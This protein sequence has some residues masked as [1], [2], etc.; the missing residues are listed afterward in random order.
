MKKV[1]IASIFATL[2]LTVPMTSVV[3][4]SVTITE[5]HPPEAPMIH[6]P[7]RV[8]PGLELVYTFNAMDP[9]GDNVS[10]FVEWGDGTC[11]GWTY[12]FP[13][14]T[15]VSFAH[16]WEQKPKY[17]RAKAKDYPY[18]AESNWS[19][20]I[21]RDKS[22]NHEL[23]N[24]EDC[25]ECQPI[26]RVDVLKVK[27]LLIK[28]KTFT[29]DILSKYGH[30][31]VVAEKCKVISD[32]ISMLEDINEGLNPVSPFQDISP[33]CYILFP[34]FLILLGVVSSFPHFDIP[35]IPI[36]KQ[37]IITIFLTITAQLLIVVG[38]MRLFDC[39]DIFE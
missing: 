19:Y 22:S 18:E 11:D 5:K 39:P 34:I 26:R 23:N 12:Y 4:T 8:K 32:N 13:S 24:R 16:T 31:P 9:D 17:I 7:L 37:I 2:M 35:D 3:G 15:D 21:F 10:Y 30:I 6:G 33:I 1:W 20:F 38:L 27:L 36:L 25:V 14:G 28:I 29:N